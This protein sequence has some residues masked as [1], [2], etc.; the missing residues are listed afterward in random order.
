MTSNAEQAGASAPRQRRRPTLEEQAR[1][2]GTRPIASEDTYALDGVW[3][4]DTEVEEFIA[5]THAARQAETS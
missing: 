2:R 3:D 4:S 5:F 1:E